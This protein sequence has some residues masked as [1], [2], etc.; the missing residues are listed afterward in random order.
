MLS[1]AAA[2]LTAPGG[3]TAAN[4]KTVVLGSG[5]SCGWVVTEVQKGVYAVQY[6]GSNGSV[7]ST[8]QGLSRK[9]AQGKSVEL[10]DNYFGSA[11][12]LGISFDFS[13]PFKNGGTWALWLEFSGVS[14]FMANS[15]TYTVCT[16]PR[17]GR[18][19]LAETKALIERLKAARAQR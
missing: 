8:G 13:L 12:S 15:G 16:G 3:T 11:H 10:S 9:T 1:A 4:S 18:S 7:A 14:A 6:L 17:T 19:H 2:M 5:S